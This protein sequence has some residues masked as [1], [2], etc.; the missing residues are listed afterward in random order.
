MRPNNE[1]TDENS[2][3]IYILKLFIL[4]YIIYYTLILLCIISYY[5]K[6]TGLNFEK[7]SSI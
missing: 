5:I 1:H 4:L 6:I 3:L 7:N 2:K